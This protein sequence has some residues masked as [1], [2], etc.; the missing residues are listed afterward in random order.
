MNW[1]DLEILWL[2]VYMY[3]MYKVLGGG[4]RSGGDGERRTAAAVG[5]GRIRSGKVGIKRRAGAD[6]KRA[7]E[8]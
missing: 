6:G 1:T 3:K 2:F 8:K 5:I 4:R 7:E